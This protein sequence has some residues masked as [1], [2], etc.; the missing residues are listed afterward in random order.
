MNA[1][2][3][4]LM[5]K[6]RELQA[7]VEADL[8]NKRAQFRY[9]LENRRVFFEQEILALHKRLRIGSL[10]Y[11]LNAP[12]LFLLTAPLI[13]SFIL[14]LLLLDLTVSV[15]QAVCFPV[16]DIPKVKRANHFVFDRESLPYLNT[17]ERLNCAYCSYANGLMAYAKEIVAR[18]EQ[19]W[20]P[21]KHARQLADSHRHYPKFFDYGDVERYRAEL[22][23]LRRDFSAD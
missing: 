11:I 12:P 14:P 9:R 22:E 7:E 21:I 23:R 8:E 17:V 2:I 5:R 6:I 4:E 18:T 16:Y 15:Y 20:C 13:Y 10:R 3:D 19:Y 1:K